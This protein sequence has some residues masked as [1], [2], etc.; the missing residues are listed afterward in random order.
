MNSI[1]NRRL[2]FLLSLAAIAVL[3]SGLSAQAETID[4]GSKDG[5]VKL[6]VAAT[7]PAPIPGTAATSAAPLTRSESLTPRLAPAAETTAPTVA[8]FED[9]D[10][11]QATL[12]GSSYIGIAANFGLDGETA[13]GDTNFTV[14]SK[15]GFLDI[16][17]L[18]PSVVIDG[19]GTAILIPVTYDF[20]IQPLDAFEEVLPIAPYAGAGVAIATGEN[21]DVGFLLT[22]GVDYAITPEFTATAAVNL[23]FMDETEIGLLVGVG[24]NFSGLLGGL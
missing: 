19:D 9:V 14:I 6:S 5:N 22:G 17:S 12:G 7:T 15:I 16:I 18:R 3:G 21:D 13:L 20:S 10:P 11:G 4:T 1:F 24:Y 23:G 2:S 8:Q